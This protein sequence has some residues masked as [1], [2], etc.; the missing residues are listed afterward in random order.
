MTVNEQ[1]MYYMIIV[2]LLLIIGAVIQ[3]FYVKSKKIKYTVLAGLLLLASVLA[4]T[5][6]V[7]TRPSSVRVNGHEINQYYLRGTESYHQRLYS[8]YPVEVN[9]RVGN[10]RPR[11]VRSLTGTQV[12]IYSDYGKQN[13]QVAGE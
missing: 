13:K 3:L 12:T 11:V 2:V 6:R 9:Y 1:G 7:E 5:T 8:L 10:E 4:F